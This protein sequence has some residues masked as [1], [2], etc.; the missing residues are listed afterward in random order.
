MPPA[1]TRAIVILAAQLRTAGIEPAC[2][3]QVLNAVLGSTVDGGVATAT[4]EHSAS[5]WVARA[6]GREQLS[7]QGQLL[8]QRQQEQLGGAPTTPL[9]VSAPTTASAAVTSPTPTVAATETHLDV[10]SRSAFAAAAA[11]AAIAATVGSASSH[12]FGTTTQVT[13]H[14]Q[15]NNN[16]ASGS[17]T[18]SGTA[19][20]GTAISIGEDDVDAAVAD[21]LR[22][23]GHNVHMSADLWRVHPGNGGEDHSQGVAVRVTDALPAHMADGQVR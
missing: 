19:T 3:P 21:V 17:G 22:S 6:S 7:G 23:V 15:N 1:L 16:G 12:S 5:V 2:N 9:R 13:A 18:Q 20:N 8:Q 14:G 4:V 11:D 10:Q